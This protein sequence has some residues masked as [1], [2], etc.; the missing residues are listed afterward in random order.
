MRTSTILRIAVLALVALPELAQARI[1]TIYD[2]TANP[3]RYHAQYVTVRA[4][5][6]FGPAHSYRLL[7]DEAYYRRNNAFQLTD[8]ERVRGCISVKNRDEIGDR[9]TQIDGRMLTLSGHFY[10]NI[11][12]GDSFFGCSKNTY[13]LAIEKILSRSDRVAPDS[14]AEEPPPEDAEPSKPQ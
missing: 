13:G 1:L 2:L 9:R 8:E 4:F 14:D 12:Y 6:A 11:G 7:Q 5:G 3:R 10:A